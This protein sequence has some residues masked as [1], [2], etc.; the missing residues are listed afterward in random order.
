MLNLL[1]QKKIIKEM[2]YSRSLSDPQNYWCGRQQPYNFFPIS[3]HFRITQENQNQLI[4][5]EKIALNWGKYFSIISKG[6]IFVANLKK[7]LYL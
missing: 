3:G 7:S 5:S 2:E 4:R 6:K 1:K